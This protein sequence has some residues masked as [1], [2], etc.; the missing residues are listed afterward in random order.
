[1]SP[2]RLDESRGSPLI[3]HRRRC[4]LLVELVAQIYHEAQDIRWCA[5]IVDLT[6]FK[7]LRYGKLDSPVGFGRV[8]LPS[9]LDA[10]I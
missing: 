7:A 9:P 5:S 1:M 10:L 4:Y 3:K 2:L 8:F 6:A